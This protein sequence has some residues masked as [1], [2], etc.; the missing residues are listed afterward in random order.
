MHGGMGGLNR[1]SVNTFTRQVT[2]TISEGYSPG[3]NVRQHPIRNDTFGVGMGIHKLVPGGTGSSHDII[4]KTD[5][6]RM[7]QIDEHIAESFLNTPA[8]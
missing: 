7:T 8:G 4:E 6:K 3:I 2:N 5:E 1:E